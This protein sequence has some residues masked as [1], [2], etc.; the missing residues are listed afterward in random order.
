MPQQ[1]FI[2]NGTINPCRFVKITTT[3]TGRV[4][5]A[6]AGSQIFG[7]SQTGIR[8]DLYIDSNGY[9]ALVGEPIG[10]F[11][12]GEECLLE[13]GGTVSAG[14]RLKSDANGKGVTT[15]TNLDEYGAIAIWSG[16]S[17]EQVRVKVQRGQIS[18]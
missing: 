8:R 9:A 5:Q 11:D 12:D 3:T 13:L 6:G 14:D 7:I 10:V 4:E 16:V 2:A 18:A 15:T 17:G 1:G